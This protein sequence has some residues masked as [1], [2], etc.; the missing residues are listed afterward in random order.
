MKNDSSIGGFVAR[1]WLRK[2]LKIIGW[3]A[4]SLIALFIILVLLIRTPVVQQWI[5]DRAT[6]WVENQTGAD[7]QIS[8]LYLTFSGNLLL[9]GVYL[10][11]LEKDSLLY[12]GSLETGV[13][14]RPLLNNEV[15]FRKLDLRDLSATVKR[16]SAGTFNFD[17]LME[18]FG[19]EGE[20]VPTKEES[21]SWD[22]FPPPLNFFNLSFNLYD[23][24]GGMNVEATLNTLN[25]DVG[26]LETAD[27]QPVVPHF[28]MDGLDVDVNQFRGTAKSVDEGPPSEL[29][30][31]DAALPHFS[32]KK[33]EWSNINFTLFN[34]EEGIDLKARFENLAL[35]DLE[36]EP[37]LS[38]ENPNRL[39]L[40]S[41]SILGLKFDG[42]IASKEVSGEVP[43]AVEE[44]GPVDFKWPDWDVQINQINFTDHTLR[45][46][47][48][49]VETVQDGFDPSNVDVALSSF[50]MKDIHLKDRKLEARLEELVAS[51]GG[52]LDIRQLAFDFF[53]DDQ[54][55]ALRDFRVK[56]SHSNIGATAEFNYQTVNHLINEPL[57]TRFSLDVKQSVLGHQDMRNFLAE[58]EEDPYMGHFLNYPAKIRGEFN[59]DLGGVNVNRFA[60]ELGAASKLGLNGRLGNL[61]EPEKITFNL[62]NVH[63]YTEE[64]DFGHLVPEDTTYSLPSR[65]LVT[66]KMR[67]TAD[68]VLFD[69]GLVIPEG[70]IEFEGQA[71]GFSEVPNYRLDMVIHALDAA[72]YTDSLGPEAIAGRLLLTGQ[73][74]DP[75]TMFAD[76]SADLNT[77]RYQ[78]KDYSPLRLNANFQEKNV[79]AGIDLLSEMLNFNLAANFTYDT[80]DF[81]FDVGFHLRKADLRELGIQ[82]DT[83]IVSTRFV[84]TGK[85]NAGL[86]DSDFS[87]DS[88]LVQQGDAMYVMD[89]LR[90]LVYLDSITTFFDVQS[91]ILQADLTANTSIEKI[92][93]G[94]RAHINSYLD[95]TMADSLLISGLEADFRMRV[96]NTRFLREVIAPDMESMEEITA[97]IRYRESTRSI[98]AHLDAPYVHY[99]DYE[100][101]G[102][103]LEAE[104][105]RDSLTF[106]TGFSNLASGAIDIQK[107]ALSGVFK[108][109]LL[110]ANLDIQADGAD[111]IAMVNFQFSALN[112]TFNLHLEPHGLVFNKEDWSISE[113]NKVRYASEYLQIRE[114]KLQ[115]RDNLFEISSHPEDKF[116]YLRLNMENLSLGGL[117]EFINPGEELA[118]GVIRGQFEVDEIFEE[119]LINAEIHIDDL[120]A[121]DIPFGNLSA[122]GNNPKKDRFEFH[123]ELRGGDIELD[124]M[125]FYDLAAEPGPVYKA[126]IDMHAV[127]FVFVEQF[128]EGAIRNSRGKLRGEV[129]ARGDDEGF[130]YDGFLMFDSVG[131]V[132]TETGS[133]FS[134]PRERIGF[135]QSEVQFLDF[136]ILD[137]SANPTWIN[138]G[139]DIQNITNPGFDLN[140]QSRNFH[141]L[142]STRQDN[143][144]FYGKALADLDVDV[145]GTLSRPVIY[146]NLDLK[147]GT[148]VTMIV[149][150]SQ[151]EIEEREG[152]VRIERRVDGQV[153]RE[154]EEEEAFEPLFTGVDLQAVITIDPNVVFRIIIDERAGDQLEVAGQANLSFDMDAEGRMSLSGIYELTRGF[155]EMRMYDIVRRRFEL[156]PGSRLIWSGDPMEAD[157]HITAVYNLRTSALD[158]MADQ[159]AGADQATRTQYRQ[160]L[161]F[162][163][164][165]DIS[166][167]LLRPNLSFSLDMPEGSR[168]ALGG[169]VYSRIQQLNTTESELNTQVFSLLVLNR[170]LPQG[171]A[172]EESRGFDAGAMARSS[173]SSILSGQLNALSDRYVRG[174]D[175]DFDLESFTDYQTGRPEDRTQLNV[176]MR[177]SLVGERLT[178]EVGGQIDLEGSDN[179]EGQSATDILG[180]V[181]IEYRLTEDGTWR[182]RGFRRNQY[183]GVMEGQVIATGVSLLFNRDFN[184][185]AELFSRKKDSEE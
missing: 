41:L 111:Q 177:R 160:E 148:D 69:M 170:F 59:G 144:F 9:E 82:E 183:E 181:N 31:E 150:E 47:D 126:D 5:T 112:D 122:F 33:L 108:D 17:F 2:V 95:P 72:Y 89:S 24:Y 104:S 14:I 175:L 52:S 48:P 79:D 45:Y 4:I 58:I 19:G 3:T 15:R 131:F 34:Q 35:L 118:D 81:A 70:N 42:K 173:A 130:E 125:G 168:G 80:T 86:L 28:F 76:L 63:L 164:L 101:F 176:R 67:G 29:G 62:R 60:L 147:R 152:V 136:T 23:K 21:A 132:M 84:A 22:I 137:G 141:F 46:R 38:G 18:T 99:L 73:G 162:E 74:F 40:E 109:S 87:L 61:T 124:L 36:L 43:V 180:D 113:H 133:A 75:N 171:V 97:S 27:F 7:C 156:K 169:N 115:R 145:T 121:M 66:G 143:D 165:L 16:D 135:T 103:F 83:S 91:S 57:E 110:R 107:T 182:L 6:S 64:R 93:G 53:A 151:V 120:V 123:G 106:A 100:V 25:L 138:G 26:S 127:D 30:E 102:T 128:S 88:L 50:L 51:E 146:A 20:D 90:A 54:Q 142:E 39:F 65:A 77:L 32:L 105:N 153:V 119:P 179:M 154:E 98:K 85:G 96:P 94:M 157:M 139:I 71:D 55:I 185:F 149:P 78:G 8:K 158:L 155:Y 12:L 10:F 140:V 159:L 92:A 37:D 174:V 163:V 134:I 161:P 44:D 166:G 184:S 13:R 167:E 56:T 68:G 114:F 11:D 178:I 117:L 129:S 49:A 116:D 172:S 1:K